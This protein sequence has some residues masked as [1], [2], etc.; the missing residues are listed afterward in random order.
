MKTMKILALLP[1]L[2]TP[3]GAPAGAP[4]RA[5][6]QGPGMAEEL[7]QKGIRCYEELSFQCAV[8]KLSAALA[9]DDGVRI[10]LYLAYSFIALD[11]RER[12]L[13]EFRK[14]FLLDDDFELNHKEVS[15][16]IYDVY[17]QAR[18]EH[19][20]I[21]ERLEK[22]RLRLEAGRREEFSWM[23]DTL[24]SRPVLELDLGFDLPLGESAAAGAAGEESYEGAI[25]A[26]GALRYGL[27]R[28][29]SLGAG[30]RY[31]S[32]E[33]SGGAA[34]DG[35]SLDILHALGFLD[36]RKVTDDFIFYVRGGGGASFT[37][38]DGLSDRLGGAALGSVGV[39]ALIG[40]RA[41]LGLEFDYQPLFYAGTP[42]RDV[43]HIFA[44]YFKILYL[45]PPWSA[46]RVGSVSDDE[47]AGGEV[48]VVR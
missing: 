40:P 28:W 32:H 37:G 35:R 5:V 11:Q 12:G 16:K 9:Y 14:I 45:F 31:S 42:G 3:L 47:V 38:L 13:E 27:A 30:A 33:L 21:K 44:V 48:S 22:E 43:T 4:G 6:A 18:Q 41:A 26:G 2:G 23:N 10:H 17:R 36:V 19:L 34:N 25:S 20:K 1:R 7:T 39:E 46:T 15:P 8:E 29:L 24:A